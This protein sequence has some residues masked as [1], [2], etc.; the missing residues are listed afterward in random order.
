MAGGDHKYA[1]GVIAFG[2]PWGLIGVLPLFSAFGGKLGGKL[3]SSALS[4][5]ALLELNAVGGVGFNIETRLLGSS[6]PSRRLI[7]RLSIDVGC[8]LCIPD[9][10]PHLRW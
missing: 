8:H 6:E 1:D 5:L 3:V 4:R 7:V 2:G 10:R 9:T